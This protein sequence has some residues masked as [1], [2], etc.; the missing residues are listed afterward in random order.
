MTGVGSI[1]IGYRTKIECFRSI[2]SIYNIT[3]VGSRRLGALYDYMHII[4]II[5][6][7]VSGG[8]CRL[9]NPIS[10]RYRSSSSA[11]V[12][13]AAMAVPTRFVSHGALSL[14]DTI[15]TSRWSEFTKD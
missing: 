9:Q 8:F 10:Q 14:K 12:A 7:S 1:V 6:E 2:R 13:Q 3:R 11:A 5:S 15:V 4:R